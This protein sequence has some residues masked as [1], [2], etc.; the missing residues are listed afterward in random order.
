MKFNMA[1][2]LR[3]IGLKTRLYRLNKTETFYE[4]NNLNFVESILKVALNL[5]KEKYI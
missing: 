3:C 5:R 2:L 1:H 4:Y